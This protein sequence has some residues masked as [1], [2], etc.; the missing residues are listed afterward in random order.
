MSTPLVRFLVGG[1]QK[2]GTTALAHYLA[3]HPGIALPRD[4]EA[5]V[6]DASW[7][8]DAWDPSAIDAAYAPMFEQ[9]AGARL[10]GDAT[11][12][13]CFH[14]RIVARIARYNPDMRWILI[15]RHPVERAYSHY[16]MER[17]RGSERWPFWAAM[18]FERWRLR[19][20]ADDLMPESPLR[21]RGY[22]A[23][24]D[25]AR[26]LDSLLAHFPR[27]QLLLLRNEALARDPAGELARAWRFLGLETPASAPV[28]ARVFEGG[29]RPLR[30][31]SLAWAIA[32]WSMKRELREAELRHG[33]GW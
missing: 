33:I 6:F 24:G 30:R 17:R 3:Q 32:R 7:F 22:G 20:H 26:Q 12:V 9:G 29:Y 27:E 1:V 21:R 13:Y 28:P 31:G 10:H 14:P 11:P 16:R 4:K 23:R 19:G 25:Y 18:L 5:H 15:L 2:G 8:D